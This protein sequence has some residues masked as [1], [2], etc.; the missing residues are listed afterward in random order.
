MPPVVSSRAKRARKSTVSSTIASEKRAR[1]TPSG[2]A[3]QPIEVD[4]QLSHRPSPRKALEDAS[5]AI[6]SPSP[7]P[8]PTFESRLRESQPEAA[9]NAPVEASEAA[10]IASEVA[11]SSDEDTFDARFSDNF[12]GIDWDRLKLYMKPTATQK[13]R[14]S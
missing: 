1:T 2:T 5:Q 12:D 3:S 11:Q 10:T 9:I 4:T 7:P 13:H 14:K 8:P 6:P